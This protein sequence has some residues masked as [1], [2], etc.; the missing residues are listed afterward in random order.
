MSNGLIHRASVTAS[1]S[2]SAEEPAASVQRKSDS[3]VSPSKLAAKKPLPI[4]AAGQIP[5]EVLVVL[6]FSV[7]DLEDQVA[8][9]LDGLL[10][11][12]RVQDSID[13][14]WQVLHEEGNAVLNA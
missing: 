2:R 8:A 1:Q 7:T 12:D 14:L 5:P 9:T 6:H 11:N 10:A 4:A 13:I 3:T